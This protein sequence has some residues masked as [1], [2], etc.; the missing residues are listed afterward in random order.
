MTKKKKKPDEE[1]LSIL[2]HKGNTNQNHIKTV[3]SQWLSSKTKN[4]GEYDGR[5]EEILIHCLWECK[6]A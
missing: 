2:G 5:G 4:V 3:L 6:L 1:M